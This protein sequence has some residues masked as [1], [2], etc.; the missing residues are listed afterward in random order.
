[1]IS[2]ISCYNNE[3]ILKDHLLKNL[4]NQTADHEL[5]L[6]DNTK[7]KFTSAAAAL[8]HGA[9][10]AKGKYLIFVH[11]DIDLMYKTWLDQVEK[12]LDSLNNLGVAGVA[13][14]NNINGKAVMI[15]NIKDGLPPKPVGIPIEIPEKVQTVD[16]CLFCIPKSVFEKLQFDDLTCPGW[17]LYS[18]EYCLN[19]KKFG[20]SVYILPCEIY[21]LSRTNSFSDEYYT[22]LKNIIKKHGSNYDK[23]IYSSCGLWSTNRF[24]LLMNIYEDKILRKFHIR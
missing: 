15:S 2:L 13:G 6:L 1:M 14:Y 12:V 17:H 9:K 23:K 11:Q 10:I 20:L 21:H 3:K 22:T 4:D 8:N 5:I 19:M 18:V 16:E 7:Q 24:R